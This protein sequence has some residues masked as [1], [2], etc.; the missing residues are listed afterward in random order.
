MTTYSLVVEVGLA[1]P[2]ALLLAALVTA[3][4]ALLVGT[5]ALRM[6]GLFLAVTTL[7]LAVAAP[8]LLSRPIF[9][10]DPTLHPVAP[11]AVAGD[12]PGLPAG[13]LLPLPRARW[14]WPSW[15]WP[16][17]G[18]AGIGRTML[19]VRDNEQAAAALGLS[20][21]RT[22]LTAFGISGFLAGLAGGLFGGLLV[23]FEPDRFLVID[24]LSVVAIAVVGGPG[25][26]HRVP[27][28]GRCSSSGS[29]PSS[30]TT[31]RSPCSPAA[32]ASSSSSSTCPAAWS[33]SCTPSGTWSSAGW[34]PGGPSPP[35]PRRCSRARPSTSP[36]RPDPPAGARRPGRHRGLGSASAPG[37]WST[38]STCTWTGA[39]SWA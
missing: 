20:P 29:P 16:A 38:A 35:K 12:L 32:S 31:P 1:F 7:A 18:A 3:A 6:T 24:S 13:L 17:S 27:S 4:V 23:S 9:T 15:S 5:P 25:V 39:R 26:D 11:P 19:A 8:W 10:D 2:S 14:S 36:A 33:R 37:W 30:P 34:P 22:K 21:T 28:W